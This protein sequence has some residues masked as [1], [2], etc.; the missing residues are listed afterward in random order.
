[1]L[2]FA[3]IPI[4]AGALDVASVAVVSDFVKMVTDLGQIRDFR[5]RLF[6]MTMR[7]GRGVGQAGFTSIRVGMP[8]SVNAGP[9]NPKVPACPADISDLFC[10][11]KNAEFAMEFALIVGH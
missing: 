4:K 7:N 6:G 8:P 2:S 1:M 5:R 10:V 9:A 11:L 3:P